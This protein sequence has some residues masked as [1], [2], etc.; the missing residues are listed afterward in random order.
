MGVRVQNGQEEI[1]IRVKN[2][3]AIDQVAVTGTVLLSDFKKWLAFSQ[4]QMPEARVASHPVM[5]RHVTSKGL[6]GR[7]NA[8]P[9]Y[10]L[11][12]LAKSRRSGRWL[13]A[14]ATITRGSSI[15]KPRQVRFQ[16][17]QACS[18]GHP[19]DVES[20]PLRNEQHSQAL[21]G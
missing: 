16:G 6:W 17:I 12:V 5:I 21:P 14:G 11:N 13:R 1:N 9:W 3:P 19:S 10:R 20:S 18:Q 15:Q 8:P 2:T 7:N 4:V